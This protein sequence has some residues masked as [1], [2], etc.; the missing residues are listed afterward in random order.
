MILKIMKNFNF[1][2]ILHYAI[3]IITTHKNLIINHPKDFIIY[4]KGFNVYI[5][6]ILI[7]I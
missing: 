1:F 5:K 6:K 2:F 7:L 3:A 4:Q